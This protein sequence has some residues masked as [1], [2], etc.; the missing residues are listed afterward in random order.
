M[1]TLEEAARYSFAVSIRIF[2]PCPQVSK[3]RSGCSLLRWIS[4]RTPAA[5]EAKPGGGDA[6]DAESKSDVVETT[7]PDTATVEVTLPAFLL[8][9]E[10]GFFKA[11]LTNGFKETHS[12]V[13][14]YGVADFEGKLEPVGRACGISPSRSEVERHRW[15]PGRGRRPHFSLLHA[16]EGYLKHEGKPLERTQLL[17]LVM[18]GVKLQADKV[19]AQSATEL[20]A[21][22]VDPETALGVVEAVPADMCSYPEI[23]AL[24]ERS[25]KALVWHVKESD[26]CH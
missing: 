6:S 19:V 10:S 17:R 20:G 4:N 11:A 25:W 2:P 18:L 8:W 23:K 12:R 26:A 16:G 3:P 24:R 5:A 14:D 7:T 15:C 13:I 22:A 9:R 21:T 1:T